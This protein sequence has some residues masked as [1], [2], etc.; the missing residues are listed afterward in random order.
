MTTRRC[1]ACLAL[2][3]CASAPVAADD[4]EIKKTAKAK[5]S[6]CQNALLKG[7]YETFVDLTHPKVVEGSG[8]RKKMIDLLTTEMKGMKAKGIVFKSVKLDD[9]S[10]PIAAGKELY[11][12]VPFTLEITVPDGRLITKSALI[13]I[14]NDGGKTWTFFDANPGSFTREKLKQLFPDLPEKLPLPKKEAPTY[15]KD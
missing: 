1:V 4:A 11:I 14:S 8:G 7:E 6:E 12:S 5:A 3:F 9:A 13:G 15:I 10:D 2:V